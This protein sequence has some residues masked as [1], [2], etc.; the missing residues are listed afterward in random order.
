[1]TNKI[2]VDAGA[3]REDKTKGLPVYFEHMDSVGQRQRIVDA[4]V[5]EMRKFSTSAEVAKTLR[6]AVEVL[7]G[8]DG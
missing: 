1:M 6:F 2:V 5:E 4:A 3:L 7:E 8:R